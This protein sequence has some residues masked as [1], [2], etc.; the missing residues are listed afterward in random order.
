MENFHLLKTDSF[1]GQK[2]GGWRENLRAAVFV[3]LACCLY[4]SPGVSAQQTFAKGGSDTCLACHEGLHE[5]AIAGLRASAH[6]ALFFQKHTAD[7]A[8]ES[9]HGPSADHA[10]KPKAHS[11]GFSLK[12]SSTQP[13]PMNQACL[14]CHKQPELIH[15]HS[16]AHA[17]TELDC[18]SCHRIHQPVQKSRDKLAG[19]AIC[20][21]CHTRQKAESQLP[22]RHPIKEGITRCIDCHNPHGTLAEAQIKQPTLNDNCYS[23]HA[24]K[25]G[26]LLFEHT[27]VTED[28]SSCHQVHGSVNPGMLTSRPPFLCQQCHMAAGHVSVASGGNNL[29]GNSN[30]LGKNCMNCHSQVHGSNHPSGARLTR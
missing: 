14:E 29:S 13:D 9:C 18:N 5:D 10:E 23:C 26:P 4:W 12:G 11:T 8:C 22:H 24:E 2:P 16:G 15:W 7:T 6:Q 27:P 17:K 20:T 3:I 28:C 30:M 19:N 1:R 25:R 21:D